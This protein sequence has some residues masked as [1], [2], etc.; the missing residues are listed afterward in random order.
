MIMIKEGLAKKTPVNATE[1][2]IEL[3]K[4]RTDRDCEDGVASLPDSDTVVGAPV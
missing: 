4:R 2:L 3:Q 1:G